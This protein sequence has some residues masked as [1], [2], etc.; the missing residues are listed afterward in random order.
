MLKK[1]S[2]KNLLPQA[3][4]EKDCLPPVIEDEEEH[5]A[6]AEWQA[7]RAQGAALASWPWPARPAMA[8]LE[9]DLK[10]FSRDPAEWSQLLIF[11]GILFL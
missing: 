3:D 2:W 11:F 8:F 10:T 5:D 4:P 1:P 9:K 7:V 6:D